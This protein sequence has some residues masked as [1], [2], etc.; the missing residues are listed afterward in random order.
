MVSDTRP[1]Y[2]KSFGPDFYYVSLGFVFCISWFSTFLSV[3]A[4][5]LAGKSVP[6]MTYFVLSGTLS[7][8]SV[9]QSV[10]S[11]NLNVGISWNLAWT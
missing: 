4:M 1:K 9:N 3:L 5:R 7:I 10:M 6:K 11:Y 8:N 2:L